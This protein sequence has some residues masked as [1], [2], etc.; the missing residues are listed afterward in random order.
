MNGWM[1]REMG[2]WMDDSEG[3]SFPR[4][5]LWILKL[6]TLNEHDL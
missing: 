2:G 5:P 1:E 6:P 4:T 3:K